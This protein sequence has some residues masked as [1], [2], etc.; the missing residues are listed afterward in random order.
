MEQLNKLWFKCFSITDTL[1]KVLSLKNPCIH[2]YVEK[3]TIVSLCRK[4]FF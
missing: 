2:K 1:S 4:L 3:K